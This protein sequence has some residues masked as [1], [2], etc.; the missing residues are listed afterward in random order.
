MSELIKKLRGNGAVPVTIMTKTLCNEA[1]TE[2]ESLQW[3]LELEATEARK[4]IQNLEHN[5]KVE[6]SQR[7]RFYR[8]VIEQDVIIRSL[9]RRLREKP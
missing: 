1:A 4:K 3:R 6:R 2:L 7:D 5:L 8:E 9:E